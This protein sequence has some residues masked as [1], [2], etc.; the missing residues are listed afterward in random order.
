MRSGRALFLNVE[1]LSLLFLAP[2]QPTNPYF[3]IQQMSFRSST[4]RIEEDD[5]QEIEA[6]NKIIGLGMK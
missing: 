2:I 4:L 5:F 6:R 3:P 1:V